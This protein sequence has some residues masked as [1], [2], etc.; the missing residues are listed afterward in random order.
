MKEIERKIFDINPQEVAQKLLDLG[1]EKTFSGLVKVRYFDTVDSKIRNQGDLLRVRQFEGAHVEV[2]YKTNKQIEDGC[3]IY[4]EYTLKGESFEDATKLFENLGFA[5]CCT[6]EKTR[7]IF[8]LEN[9]EVVIDEYPKM[10]PF[11]EV[12]AGDAKTIDEIVSRLGLT[13]NESSC[14][15]INELIK[16]KYPDL[17]LNNLTFE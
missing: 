13:E 6:Y 1:A 10:D 5:V 8:K 2:V 7:T 9:A 3:K 12:E 11:V 17:D 15:T 16:R 14:E 4:D